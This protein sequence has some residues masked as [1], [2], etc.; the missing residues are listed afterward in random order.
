M[1]ISAAIVC[2][3]FYSSLIAQDK[4][5]NIYW[6]RAWNDRDKWQKAD[7]LIRLLAIS[8]GSH[9]ADV[10]C[11]EGYMTFKLAGVVGGSGVVYAVDVLEFRLG[12]VR[13]R[14]EKNK[15]TQVKVIKGEYDNPKLPSG[16]LDA[17]LIL[18]TY[19]EMDD[20]E[21][22]LQH[23]KG[24]LKPGGRLMICDP[25]ADSRRKAS[26][27]EQKKKHELGMEYALAD[28]KKAGFK[29]LFQKDAFIDRMKA[30]GD[31][32]WVVLA[33]NE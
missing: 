17:V 29:I 23:I 31:K 19:H 21:E 15:L 7:E 20:H 6:Q 13:E 4:W 5:K 16:T 8:S 18:D 26:R 27:S 3:F 9:V 10:G 11:H 1:K 25:I 33:T 30:K 22:I 2:V 14:A 28:L 12:K 24:S 32:M